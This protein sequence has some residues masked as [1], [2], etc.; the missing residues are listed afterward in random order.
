M[1]YSTDYSMDYSTSIRKFHSFVSYSIHNQ[2]F[3]ISLWNGILRDGKLDD[4]DILF[5][6]AKHPKIIDGVLSF[7]D[8]TVQLT[9]TQ[10]KFLKF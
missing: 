4:I 9:P 2:T 1:D 6:E 8:T 7:D 10:L 5:F 3:Y